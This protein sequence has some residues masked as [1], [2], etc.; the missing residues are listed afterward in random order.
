MP[1]SSEPFYGGSFIQGVGSFHKTDLVRL[2]RNRRRLSP[3]QR[4]IVD[5]AS[6]KNYKT[7]NA[8]YNAL[9]KATQHPHLTSQLAPKPL[10]ANPA[11]FLTASHGPEVLRGIVDGYSDRPQSGGGRRPPPRGRGGDRPTPP[12]QPG[13]T[14]PPGGGDRPTPPVSPGRAPQSDTT[15]AET[16]TPR[17]QTRDFQ[18]QTRIVPPTGIAETQTPRTQ[19]RDFQEQVETLRDAPPGRDVGV[20]ARA[21]RNLA[22]SEFQTILQAVSGRPPTSDMD[23]QVQVLTDPPPT[24]SRYAQAEP[25]TREQQT[26]DVP[27]G[28]RDT[29]KRR[30]DESSQSDKR[31]K[32]EAGKA[33]EAS[34]AGVPPRADPGRKAQFGGS[35]LREAVALKRKRYSSADPFAP[36]GPQNKSLKRS[37]PSSEDVPV[38]RGPSRV[39]P[40]ARHRRH[41]NVPR[42]TEGVALQPET[43]AAGYLASL[44]NTSTRALPHIA[45]MCATTV[46]LRGHGTLAGLVEIMSGNM[47]QT[48]IDALYREFHEVAD[49]AGLSPVADRLGELQRQ[50]KDYVHPER[51]RALGGPLPQE[52]QTLMDEGR[53]DESTVQLMRSAPQLTGNTDQRLVLHPMDAETDEE[54]EDWTRQS[55]RQIT[56]EGLPPATEATTTR[57]LVM[58]DMTA[59]LGLAGESTLARSALQEAGERRLVPAGGAEGEGAEGAEP[60]TV[61]DESTSSGE[62]I[63]IDEAEAPPD[64]KAEEPFTVDDEDG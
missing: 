25:S 55:Y 41:V 17:T 27:E 10:Q 28:T 30:D 43:T 26:Q 48:T 31:R 4:R 45:L 3:V 21:Q 2:Q 33:G 20:Q 42:Y 8:L 18:E 15:T 64:E 59:V 22:M 9:H 50:I 13:S 53:L 47:P 61:D 16:Q 49:Q 46:H 6:Q 40:W 54:M 32:P 11:T 34:E 5:L 57:E 23:T 38:R 14:P 36:S 7:P 51:E 60:F 39:P 19:T 24:T 44:L 1:V 29:G 63:D 58:G 35:R 52:L 56:N 12:V 37:E 62:A